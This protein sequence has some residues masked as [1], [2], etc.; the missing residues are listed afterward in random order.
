MIGGMLG[1]TGLIS[2]LVAAIGF[3]ILGLWLLAHPKPGWFRAGVA[4]AS[5]LTALWAGAVVWVGRYGGSAAT[6]SLMETVRS[7]AWIALL[8]L[9][10]R[11]FWGL[12]Q[13]PSSSFFVALMLGFVMALQVTMDVLFGFGAD[14]LPLGEQ[15]AVAMLY[16]AT[17][18]LVAISGLVLVHNLYVNSRDTLGPEVRFFAVGLGAIFAYDLNLYTLQ[19]LLGELS[20]PLWNLRGAV[21]TLALPLIALSLRGPARGGFYMSRNVAFNTISF[22]G[23]GLYLITMSLLAYVLR[24]AGGDWGLVL[25]VTFLAA[26][27]IF[28]AL[29]VLSPR[30]RAT[31]RVWIS[32][33][34]YRYRYDYRT[35]WLRF[36]DKIDAAQVDFADPQPIRERLIEALATVID[37]PGGALFEPGDTGGWERTAQ[38]RWP[39]LAIRALSR[40]D[41]LG[42]W[43]H[44]HLRVVDFEALRAEAAGRRDL[45]THP[46]LV[47]PD[48]ADPQTGIWLAIP[49]SHRERLT[50]FIL[51][52]DSIAPRDLNWE[53]YD[54]LRTLGRQGASYLVEAATQAALDEARSFEE[55]NRRFAFAMHDIKNLVSQMALVARNAERHADK[56]EFREDMIATLRNSVTKMTDLLALLG[57]E[58]KKPA[59]PDESLPAR[60]Q[61]DLA[62][63]LT[64][65]VA[66]VRR[67]HPAVDLSGADAPLAISGDPFRLDSMIGHIL[68]N[69]AEASA[70]DA[71]ISV[72]LAQGDPREAVIRIV[73][74]GCGMTA[75]FI[76]EDLFR[77]FR[78]TKEGGYGIG[79]YEAREIARSHGGSLEVES[80]PGEGSSFTIRLPR[81]PAAV[82]STSF[83]AEQEQKMGT[84]K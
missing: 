44:T 60:E 79:A 3:A 14:P 59:P 28:G 38:W 18:I 12:D 56:P 47:P 5:L 77:P 33:N 55:F 50:G 69:A 15:P 8:I 20:Q 46:G 74:H 68:Q 24:L 42:M 11:Q 64:E 10:L 48:W 9:H 7:A 25:Q 34:F 27:L 37:S 51:L 49:L 54:L 19:F 4:V 45:L 16:V 13:R 73:D 57:R 22:S 2:H 41:P 29:A 43:M 31:L 35:E 76:R 84:T 66:T 30:L 21:N 6:L 1:A 39:A 58:A 62:A 17:R 80:R 63:L 71:V 52:E 78:S 40:D 26:T 53:D 67:R 72:S 81:A 61:V 32:R 82:L 83:P 65:A 23:I 70:P 75:S 36:M